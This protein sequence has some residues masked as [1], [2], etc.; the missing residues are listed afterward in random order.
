MAQ[1]SPLKTSLDELRWYR[2]VDKSLRRTL[3]TAAMLD[4]VI[5]IGELVI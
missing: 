3:L 2:D 5:V 1:C 4:T